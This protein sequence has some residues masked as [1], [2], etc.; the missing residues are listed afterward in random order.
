MV[1]NRYYNITLLLI[2][3]ILTT[4]CIFLT[5]CNNSYAQLDTLLFTQEY[6]KQN[7]VHRFTITPQVKRENERII[8][9]NQVF[10]YT[11]DTVGRI[12]E[13]TVYT[14]LAGTNIKDTSSIHYGYDRQGRMYMERNFDHK[15]ITTHYT[16]YNE[17]NRN[18]KIITV[19]ETIDTN[20]FP[21]KV[22]SQ[23]PIDSAFLKYENVN[24]TSTKCTYY[25]S[26]RLPYNT[27]IIETLPN[28]ISYM[29]QFSITSLFEK[30]TI[31][32]LGNVI[33]ATTE[34]SNSN[35]YNDIKTVYNYENNSLKQ[36]TVYIN[37]LQNKERFVFYENN[38]IVNEI[39]KYTD[40][41]NLEIVKYE[42]QFYNK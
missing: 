9:R 41:K 37:N 27:I 2:K 6:F 39:N 10:V 18:K 36:Q 33:E 12:I 19:T 16:M 38:V 28:S 13:K 17:N 8:N 4:L 1:L 30:Y 26:Y 42:Y 22:L 23:T 35:G 14:S 7:K 34:T 3:T 5:V 29:K 20:V 21:I 24:A 40:H 32:R 25:N 31:Q 11:L 15:T